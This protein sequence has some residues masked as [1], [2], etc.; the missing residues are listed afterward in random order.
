MKKQIIA[1]L[2][3]SLMVLGSTSFA[4][5]RDAKSYQELTLSQQQTY[6]KLS[7]Q[8]K[9]NTKAIFGFE[10]YKTQSTP[11]NVSDDS[12]TAK[13]DGIKKWNNK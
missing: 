3:L 11:Y 4:N 2:A 12:N 9:Q 7:E 5:A 1:T 13:R 6:N 8:E 10:V